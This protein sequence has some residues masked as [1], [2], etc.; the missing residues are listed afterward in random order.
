M[1]SWPPWHKARRWPGNGTHRTIG[2]LVANRIE[3]S[4]LG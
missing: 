3:Q 4:I 1:P 2:N